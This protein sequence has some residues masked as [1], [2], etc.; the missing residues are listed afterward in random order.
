MTTIIAA[1]GTCVQKTTS[2]F[3][4]L[5][6]GIAFAF[7]CALCAPAQA[8]AYDSVEDEARALLQRIDDCQ[9]DINEANKAIEQAEKD[10]KKAMKQAKKAKAQMKEEQARIDEYQDLLEQ[11]SV[12]MY[13]DARAEN[14]LLD[15]LDADTFDELESKMNSMDTIAIEQSKLIEDARKA[16]DKLEKAKRTYDAHAE[17]AREH[18]KAAEKA[19]K[20]AQ[21]RHEELITEAAKITS[22]IADS[23]AR[24]SLA[25][26]IASKAFPEGSSLENPCPTAV[27]SSEFGYRDFDHSFHQGLDLA[28]EEGTPYYAAA[29]GTVIYATNDGKDNGGAGNWVVIAHGN[30]I[31]TKY[32]HSQETYVS[33]GDVVTQGQLIGLVGQTGAAFGAHLHFQ[34]EVDGTAVDPEKAMN[35]PIEA[36]TDDA[37]AV[38]AEEYFEQEA[39]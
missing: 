25:S 24:T 33:P 23:E 3:I 38:D 34:V 22:E 17:E 29:P 1:I 37:E 2:L 8:V 16:R 6:F 4:T 36:Q 30:G 11:L 26:A 35:G 14:P 21:Q 19:R 13:K 12:T 18:K 32:M 27:K 39:E 7:V 20:E 28:A 10:Y 9:T 15:L 31:V 5:F